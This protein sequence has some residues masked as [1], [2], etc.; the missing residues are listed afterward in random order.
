VETHH[1]DLAL[2]VEVGD[3]VKV[4]RGAQPDA[5]ACIKGEAVDLLEGFSCR[6]PLPQVA[7]NH[8]WLVDGLHQVFD[9]S[10]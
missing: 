7:I 1:P 10:G 6:G 2:T 8:R 4:R 5:T 9:V 3:Q